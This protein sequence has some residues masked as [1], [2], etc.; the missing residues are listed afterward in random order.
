MICKRFQL[1]GDGNAAVC[2][3]VAHRLNGFSTDRHDCRLTALRKSAAACFR[4]RNARRRDLLRAGA[5]SVFHSVEADQARPHAREGRGGGSRFGGPAR[6][7]GGGKFEAVEPRWYPAHALPSQKLATRIFP[8]S[9]NFPSSTT[10]APR[11]TAR[12]FIRPGPAAGRSW[13]LFQHDMRTKCHSRLS[14]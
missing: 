12:C 7:R 8:R 14:R 6:A 1:L 3:S 9:E 13:P 4:L 5:N 2:Q 10:G 11:G